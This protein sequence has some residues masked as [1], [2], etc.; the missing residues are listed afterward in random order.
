MVFYSRL[1]ISEPRY[2]NGWTATNTGWSA[3]AVSICEKYISS[4]VRNLL[5]S[6]KD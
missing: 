4:F 5:T 1:V 2:L 6:L 3:P